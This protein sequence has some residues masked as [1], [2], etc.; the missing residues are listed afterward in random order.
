[1]RPCALATLYSVLTL[2]TVTWDAVRR[3]P[4]AAAVQPI[5]PA[6]TTTSSLALPPALIT[7][8]PAVA[9][10]SAWALTPAPAAPPALL[11]WRASPDATSC[12]SFSD[13]A[14]RSALA[15]H[16]ADVAQAQRN[17]CAST[18][19]GVAAVAAAGAAARRKA[20]KRRV[21]NGQ[22]RARSRE[23]SPT[24][25]SAELRGVPSVLEA[26]PPA[27]TSAQLTQS[28]GLQFCGGEGA[29]NATTESPF[30]TPR[31]AARAAEAAAAAARAWK[32][33]ERGRLK[34]HAAASDD[35]CVCSP[36]L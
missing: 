29:P 2:T 1:M 31:R 28:S 23:E 3:Q 15:R 9:T 6:S 24:T 22:S 35:D 18:L 10:D 19:L 4:P 36:R 5:E 11:A 33:N 32:R 34:S 14:V 26:L 25:P 16:A 17:A 20:A 30:G 27:A 21:G 7:S 12:A 8:P 13:A